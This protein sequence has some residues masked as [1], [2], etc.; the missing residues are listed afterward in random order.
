MSNNN[1]NSGLGTAGLVLGILAFFINPLYICS[2]LAIIFGAVGKRT[3]GV[4]LGI[5]SLCF[6]FLLDLI[7]TVFSLG[8]GFMVFCC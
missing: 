5:I 3:S 4:V 2:I 1:S 8:T 7:I 6:Q